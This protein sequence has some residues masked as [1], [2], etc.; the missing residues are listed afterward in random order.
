LAIQIITDDTKPRPQ[1]QRRA[2]AYKAARVSEQKAAFETPEEAEILSKAMN[3]SVAN[4]LFT[5]SVK[6]TAGQFVSYFVEVNSKIPLSVLQKNKIIKHISQGQAGVSRGINK[7]S[8]LRSMDMELPAKIT[9]DGLPQ[10][11][12]IA[13]NSELTKIVQELKSELKI[14]KHVRKHTMAKEVSGV[15]LV[16]EI[17]RKFHS[18]SGGEFF[19]NTVKRMEYIKSLQNEMNARKI[20]IEKHHFD[21]HQTILDIFTNP[22]VKKEYDDIFARFPKKDFNSLE[23]ARQSKFLRLQDVKLDVHSFKMLADMVPLKELIDVLQLSLITKDFEAVSPADFQ[24]IFRHEL[25]ASIE[26]YKNIYDPEKGQAYNNGIDEQKSAKLTIQLLE[27]MMVNL[28]PEVEEKKTKG[29]NKEIEEE[30]EKNEI[31][32]NAKFELENAITLVKRRVKEITREN[33]NTELLLHLPWNLAKVQVPTEKMEG[34]QI[35]HYKD[36]TET[37]PGILEYKHSE[38]EISGKPLTIFFKPKITNDLPDKPSK[39]MQALEKQSGI[40][41]IRL[42]NICAAPEYGIYNPNKA[43]FGYDEIV[44]ENELDEKG[45]PKTI[46]VKSQFNVTPFNLPYAIEHDLK[47]NGSLAIREING[48]VFTGRIITY[49]KLDPHLIT[50]ELYSSRVSLSPDI[51]LSAI[52]M[53]AWDESKNPPVISPKLISTDKNDKSLYALKEKIIAVLLGK[54]HL[55][56]LS[57][58]ELIQELYGKGNKAARNKIIAEV[59][60]QGPAE[61]PAQPALLDNNAPKLDGL[62][63]KLIAASPKKV[64]LDKLALGD[65]LMLGYF[66]ERASAKVGNMTITRNALTG[67]EKENIF[68][69]MKDNNMATDGGME[70]IRTLDQQKE[71]RKIRVASKTL[72]K[73]N[74][75]PTPFYKREE[76][77][78]NLNP[79]SPVFDK[80]KHHAKVIGVISSSTSFLQKTHMSRKG[81]N[82]GLAEIE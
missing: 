34:L 23:D 47:I 43:L 35:A 39:T 38:E 26:A 6:P 9:L 2:A 16:R 76:Y 45:N 78:A 13:R 57:E 42:I 17:F 59:N 67:K 8:V 4:E 18:G 61:N 1:D 71:V 15:M 81:K 40:K 53:L 72:S 69:A 14:T 73:D 12:N 31:T 62:R 37:E 75:A 63:E 5:F 82:N 32:P 68:K 25:K 10:A 36:T 54:E 46:E 33:K 20:P 56:E 79:N 70:I 27:K 55:Y 52:K 3:E 41:L 65:L 30:A 44:L 66:M 19:D 51:A 77:Y 28:L 48:Q 50:N 7:E 11:L 58:K 60:L 22:E 49:D 64:K 24:F 29:K 74:F 21:L 80:E